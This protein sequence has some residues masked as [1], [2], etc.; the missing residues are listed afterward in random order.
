MVDGFQ[1]RGK[2]FPVLVGDVF[3][4]VPYHMYDAALLLRLRECRR[5]GFLNARE[6]VRAEN[7][8]ILHTAVLQLVQNAEPVLGAFILPDLY[9]QDFLFTFQRK[10][11]DDIG[12]KLADYPVLPH[13]IMDCVD[14]DHGIDFLQ[15]A[16]LPVFNLRQ[17]LV[18][19]V[20][21]EP[22]RSLKTINVHQGIRDLAGCHA[23]CI[24]G[25][26]LLVNAGNVLLALSYH[27]GFKRG[28]PVLGHLDVHAPEAA[29]DP[30]GLVAIAV[31]IRIRPF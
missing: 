24:H 13:G 4:R 15:R 11:E 22:F 26:D 18:R 12:G 28:L 14:V 20:R 9:A 29:V 21:D 30:L 1:V 3:Q 8:D 5:Y 27:L 17:Y 10:A 23:F 7:E 19:H 25:Y 31:I 16:V 2:C 6:P